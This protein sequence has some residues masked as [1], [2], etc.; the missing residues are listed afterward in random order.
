MN[1]SGGK[2]V[3]WLVLTRR[4]VGLRWVWGRV[5]EGRLRYLF[6]V[7]Y[8]T[9]IENDEKND[10]DEKSDAN[11]WNWEEIG[12]GWEGLSTHQWWSSTLHSACRTCVERCEQSAWN[13][14]TKIDN[15][16][17]DGISTTSI[18]LL[19]PNLH[20][21]YSQYSHNGLWMYHTS[22]IPSLLPDLWLLPLWNA[23]PSDYILQLINS[24]YNMASS[25]PPNSN[26]KGGT[27]L[28][29]EMEILQLSSISWCRLMIGSKRGINTSMSIFS[30]ILTLTDGNLSCLDGLSEHV[31]SSFNEDEI[32]K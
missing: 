15:I 10:N 6:L 9:C 8:S 31:F 22:T 26:E 1:G 29:L 14:L 24:D 2:P 5:R 21:N 4:G 28:H 11:S 17:W 7:E 3:T 18:L 30:S 13:W 20:S 19:F 27:T 32:R 25:I 12:D 16:H 23:H